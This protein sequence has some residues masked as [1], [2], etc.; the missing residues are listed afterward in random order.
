MLNMIKNMINQKQDFLEAAEL[1]LE[2][3]MDELDDEIILGESTIFN[4]SEDDIQLEGED[5]ENE[6]EKPAENDG[7]NESENPTDNTD[8]DIMDEPIVDDGLGEED[9][10][11]P[12]ENNDDIMNDN[13]D[14]PIEPEPTT[15]PE[16][17]PLPIPGDDNLP[18]PVSNVTGEPVADDGILNMEIDLG[19][20]TPNDILPIPPANAGD[21]VVED[22][23]L[24][25]RIDSGFGE[26][27]DV[28]KEVIQ[29]DDLG[30]LTIDSK[31]VSADEVPEHIRKKG[32]ELMNKNKNLKENTDDLLNESID[33]DVNEFNEKVVKLN[34]LPEEAKEVLKRIIIEEIKKAPTIKFDDID[35][36]D[37]KGTKTENVDFEEF[38]EKVIKVKSDAF[39][40]LSGKTKALVSE[41]IKSKKPI[42]IEDLKGDL[43]VELGADDGRKPIEPTKILI[44][45]TES[46]D[47]L[48]SEAITIADP[49]E[50]S[51]SNEPSSEETSTDNTIEDSSVTEEVPVEDTPKDNEVT[52]AV[53]D[54]V[55]EVDS[56][57]YDGNTSDAKEELMKKLSNI[58]KN[59]EDAKRAV[60]SA[61]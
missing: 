10:P 18:E 1:I 45:I 29:D 60:M 17:N 52:A 51:T 12:T 55:A 32:E 3:G 47:D 36:V 16:E 14:S 43:G 2:N 58:T 22:N 59:L 49:D 61:I 41:I 15:E 56:P 21:A 7:N 35:K 5:S 42:S 33:G 38:D 6:L 40:N 11:V 28:A 24:N 19:S 50:N 53:K 44:K 26:S 57:A 54:K 46:N 25:Q 4:E 37:N 48:L 34:N 8:G 9:T 13:V 31:K 27:N 23:I 39:K 30:E 20:N